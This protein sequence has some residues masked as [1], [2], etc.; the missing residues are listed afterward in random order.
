ML[1]PKLLVQLFE[2]IEAGILV[3]LLVLQV[4]RQVLKVLRTSAQFRWFFE[5]IL[6][7]GKIFYI[8]FEP[9][10]PKSSS[11]ITSSAASSWPSEWYF[12]PRGNT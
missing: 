3:A 7:K 10:K 8:S 5:S 4:R 11:T 1:V 2:G 12:E 6:S 9:V